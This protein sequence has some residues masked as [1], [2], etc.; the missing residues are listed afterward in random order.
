MMIYKDASDA[1]NNITTCSV[2]KNCG[3]ACDHQNPIVTLGTTALR[4]TIT[5]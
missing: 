4:I 3:T 2:N 1:S 5:I